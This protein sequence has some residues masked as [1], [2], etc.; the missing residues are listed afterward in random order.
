MLTLLC[1]SD[2]TDEPHFGSGVNIPTGATTIA[3]AVVAVHNEPKGETF[4]RDIVVRAVIRVS[5]TGLLLVIDRRGQS[6]HST[7]VIEGL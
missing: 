2:P 4:A 7:A 5:G 1:I 3:V 6:T